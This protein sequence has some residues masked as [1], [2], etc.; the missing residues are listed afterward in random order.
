MEST[1]RWDQFI[2][3]AGKMLAH[4]EWDATERDYKLDIASHVA[5][6]REAF[7][8]GSDEWQAHLKRAFGAPANPVNWRVSS[9]FWKL[10]ADH[11]EC[12]NDALRALWEHEDWSGVVQFLES[13]SP[14]VVRGQS[15]RLSLTS[16]LLTGIN[17]TNYPY[18]RSTPFD[19]GYRLV[20]YPA[21]PAEADDAST[22]QH[23]IEFTDRLI[24]EAGLRG[25]T[26][27]DRL[28]AQSVIWTMNRDG[29]YFG[30]EDE[31]AFFEFKGIKPSV[32]APAEPPTVIQESTIQSI[33][34]SQI[35]DDL[36]DQLLLDPAYLRNVQRLLE[37]KRQ[38]IF[39]GPPG[40]GKTFV[41]RELA[42]FFAGD[43]ER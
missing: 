15:A 6:A 33:P 1:E 26:I 41:A 14:D 34:A 37:D 17:P 35:L 39:Y 8:S 43:P 31:A 7:Q 11:P 16:L 13:I 18:Y 30:D 10:H 19:N 40:T 2:H 5:R 28:D 32:A 21:P 24:Q 38:V 36:A 22:Y 42:K 3:F 20:G 23:A 27:R 9:A 4:P 25:L 12:V 29:W